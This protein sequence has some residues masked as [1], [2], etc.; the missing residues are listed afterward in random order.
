MDMGWHMDMD[1]DMWAH[2]HGHMDMGTWTWA[3]GMGT[4]TWAHGHGHMAWTWTWGNG[5]GHMDMDKAQRQASTPIRANI[6]GSS[7]L[8][9]RDNAARRIVLVPQSR[10]P[11]HRC[12]EHGGRGWEAQILSATNV[13]AVVRYLYARSADGRPYE[14][15]REPLHL[16]EALN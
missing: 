13:S 4:W 14:D 2:E 12:D 8:L 7:P 3:H 11:R 9:T 1:M 15:T 10:Y 6:A 5:H 16:L